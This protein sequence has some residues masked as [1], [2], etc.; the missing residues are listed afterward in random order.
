MTQT[1]NRILEVLDESGFMLTP[2]VLARNLEYNR[3]WVS[4]RRSKLLDAE[5]IDAPESSF[6]RI[7]DKCRAY[8]T[9]ELDANLENPG[10]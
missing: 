10:E 9:G 1:D 2:V 3:S 5:L 8:L 6:Y 7:T 4:R